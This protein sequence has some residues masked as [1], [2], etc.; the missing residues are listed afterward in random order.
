MKKLIILIT[1]SLSLFADKAYICENTDNLIKE[2]FKANLSG[3][4]KLQCKSNVSNQD[5]YVSQNVLKAQKDA[6]EAVLN[7]DCGAKGTSL[8]VGYGHS[9]VSFDINAFTV[10][11]FKYVSKLICS[12]D[13][14]R[15]KKLALFLGRPEF[16]EIDYY[17][18]KEG[19]DEKYIAAADMIYYLE[20]AERDS[21][22]GY[23]GSV[24]MNAVVFK[25]AVQIAA[26]QI[27]FNNLSKNKYYGHKNKDYLQFI[28]YMSQSRYIKIN[29]IIDKV[30]LSTLEDYCSDFED[31]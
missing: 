12:N 26:R 28:L 1:L 3:M 5:S 6:I 9:S 8:T 27:C 19:L 13:I 30:K 7:R 22:M 10:P 17:V 23:T 24:N 31:L 4:H 18:E 20:L 29:K 25:N 2:A 21:V 16:S 14:T 15:L 11:Y